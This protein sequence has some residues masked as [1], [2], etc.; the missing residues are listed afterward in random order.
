MT[1]KRPYG[2]VK[3]RA[4]GNPAPQKDCPSRECTNCEE[5]YRGKRLGRKDECVAV[6]A[7]DEDSPG[8]HP[9]R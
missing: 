1:C 7:R 5:Y 9:A 3:C 4:S 6:R 8:R 2:R